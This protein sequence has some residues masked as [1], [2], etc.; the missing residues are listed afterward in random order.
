MPPLSLFANH[1]PTVCWGDLTADFIPESSFDSLPSG[2]PVS[3]VLVFAMAQ[4]RFVV[5]DIAG[6]GW[7]IPGG[8]LEA[9]ETPLEA[10]H[11][12]VHEE[13]GGTIEAP[14][15]LG[16]YRLTESA[17]A[18]SIVPTFAAEA[19]GYGSPP[20]ETESNGVCVLSWEELPSRYFHWDALIEAVFRYA[21]LVYRPL[22]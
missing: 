13:T 11:R 22:P 8:R 17:G 18:Q 20:P 5:A 19:H 1:F 9:G 12:E 14:V 15:L 4:G 21:L 10:L 7:C 16:F 6:R 2:V 3:A